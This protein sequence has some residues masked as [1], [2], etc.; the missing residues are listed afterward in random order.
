MLNRK[1]VALL[2]LAFAGL[3]LPS[4]SA[5]SDLLA[6][7]TPTSTP[8]STLT[9]TTTS[10]PTPT[11]TPTV[12]LTPTST[13]RPTSLSVAFELGA[14]EEVEGASYTYQPIAEYGTTVRPG[15]VTQYIEADEFSLILTIAERPALP[16]ED[17]REALNG[18]LEAMGNDIGDL[19]FGEFYPITVGEIEGLATDI[20]GTIFDSD[21]AG[22]VVSLATSNDRIFFGSGLGAV[23]PQKDYWQE[24]GDA[25][26][27]ALLGTIEFS[28]PSGDIPVCLISDDPSY[29]FSQENPIK[30]GGGAFVGPSRE[31]A[32]LDNLLGPNG[33]AVSYVR[34]GSFPLGDVILDLYTVDIQGVGTVSLYIDEYNYVGLQAPVGFTCAEAF[35]L[36]P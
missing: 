18:F 30:V 13:P 35:I 31:R 2:L 12:T 32:Y 19:I 20:A 24:E 25:A 5:I 34:S 6:T 22:Q 26:F 21:M 27:D 3:Y 1:I 23:S 33:E 36:G 11:F 15:Q 7:P 17:A 14:R 9:P 4:C 16:S 28:Q 8:T 10:T 29:G